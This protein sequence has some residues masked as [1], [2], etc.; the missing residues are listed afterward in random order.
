L[1]KTEFLTSA[2]AFNFISIEKENSTIELPVGTLAFTFCQVPFVY[3]LAEQNLVN[4]L[5]V[6]G[7][8]QEAEG[9]EINAIHSNE[10]FN[11]T[12]AIKQVDVYLTPRL[13]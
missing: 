7:A 8:M 13:A 6:D 12:G 3:H 1:R 4:I 9:L 10:I 11:R 2:K 5:T